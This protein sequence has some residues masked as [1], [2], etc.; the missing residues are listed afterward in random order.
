MIPIGS[1][2]IIAHIAIICVIP[3]LICR[4]FTGFE[5]LTALR[6]ELLLLTIC[7]QVAKVENGTILR[8]TIGTIKFAY[9]HFA[10]TLLWRQGFNFGSLRGGWCDHNLRHEALGHLT[11]IHSIYS[12]FHFC[13]NP[14]INNNHLRLSRWLLWLLHLRQGEG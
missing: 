4:R 1:L 7:V 3:L 12:H 11:G 6:G 9:V 13:P 2:I 14:L 8:F 10:R 5:R